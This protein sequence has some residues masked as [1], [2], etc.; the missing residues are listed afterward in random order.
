M[1]MRRS[2]RA[3]QTVD[4]EGWHDE[5]GHGERERGRGDGSGWGEEEDVVREGRGLV[6][7][8]REGRL[9]FDGKRGE[10]GQSEGL[11]RRARASGRRPNIDHRKV[12]EQS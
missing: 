9:S 11:R 12:S 5:G 4:R 10:R 7:G 1:R 3:D 6:G 2:S 8:G